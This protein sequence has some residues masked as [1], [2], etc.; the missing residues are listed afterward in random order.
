MYEDYLD[1]F[2]NYL[3]SSNKSEVTISQYKRELEKFF[4]FLTG[5]GVLDVK[6]IETIHIDLYQGNLMKINKSAS[7]AKKI[8]ALKSFFKYLRGRKYITDNPMDAI[9]SVKIKDADRKK[10]ENLTKKEALHLI[11]STE[12]NSIP[13]MQLKNKVLMMSFLFFG[14]RV[15]ELCSLKVEDVSFQ[16]KTIYVFDGKGGK[17]RE[18]PLFDELV[19]AFKE[20]LKTKKV[21]SDYFFTTK[22]TDR[23]MQPRAVLDLVKRHAKRA[24]IKKNIGCHTL[25]RSFATMLYEDGFDLR[26][27]QLFLGHSSISTTL[28]YINKDLE[29]TKAEVRKGFSL[30]KDLKKQSKDK[31]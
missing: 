9:E 31:K 6:D 28:L 7:V 18:V 13:T 27:I 24:R 21:K 26:T 16:N 11:D 22:Q 14:L 30:A 19:P 29:K 1:L 4:E 2:I 15:S 20:Y 10:K 17:N 25:R 12:K 5:K 8:Y 23:P 3:E